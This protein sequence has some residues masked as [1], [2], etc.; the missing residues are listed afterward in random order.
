MQ[1][2]MDQMVK[3]GVKKVDCGKIPGFHSAEG[4]ELEQW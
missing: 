2:K 4:V 1:V 3:T